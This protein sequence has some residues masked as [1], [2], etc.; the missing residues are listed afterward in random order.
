MLWQK[1]NID[2]ALLPVQR[3][4]CEQLRRGVGKYGRN[5]DRKLANSIPRHPSRHSKNNLLNT[6]PLTAAELHARGLRDQPSLQSQESSHYRYIGGRYWIGKYELALIGIHLETEQRMARHNPPHDRNLQSSK[7]STSR[8]KLLEL[9]VMK[10]KYRDS[11]PT[12]GAKSD[13]RALRGSIQA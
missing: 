2:E 9:G 13:S 8:R 1:K 6:S 12:F 3:A 7:D 4:A 11:L 10:S 5:N